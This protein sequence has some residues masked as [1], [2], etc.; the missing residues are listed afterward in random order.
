MLWFNVNI[1]SPTLRKS[2]RNP[3]NKKA[4]YIH[5]SDWP[6]QT[7]SNGRK[8]DEEKLPLTTYPAAQGPPTVSESPPTETEVEVMVN[9][10]TVDVPTDP[11]PPT[12]I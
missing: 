6:D 4:L 9:Q 5:S 2:K 8:T 10:G 12:Q 3:R 7:T 11:V 1:L